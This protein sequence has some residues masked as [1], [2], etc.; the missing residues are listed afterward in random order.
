MYALYENNP[1]LFIF[2]DFN[3][4]QIVQPNVFGT[5]EDFVE[6]YENVIL[7]GQYSNSSQTEQKA[8]AKRTRRLNVLSDRFIHRRDNKIL[9]NTIPNKCEFAVYIR[10]SKL[11]QKLYAV[12]SCFEKR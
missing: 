7:R 9:S 10:P 8:M 11:Q 5:Y 1:R 2:S 6:K 4:V 3:M 12:R